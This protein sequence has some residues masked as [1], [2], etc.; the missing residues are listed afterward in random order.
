MKQQEVFNKIG[1][2][3]KELSDQYEYLKTAEDPLN[4]LELELFLA[5]SHFLTDH[6]V[7]LS[8]LNAQAIG[9]QKVKE[10]EKKSEPVQPRKSTTAEPPKNTEEPKYFEPLVQQAPA[11]KN[12]FESHEVSAEEPKEE[13]AEPENIILNEL[14]PV[15][16]ETPGTIRH[17][18]IIDEADL[19]DDDDLPELVEDKA[20]PVKPEPRPEPKPEPPIAAKEEKQPEKEA[21]EPKV[22]KEHVKQDIPTIN[23]RMSAQLGERNGISENI[24]LQPISDLKAAN[25]MN[26]KLL[27]VK[28]LFNGY[29][30]AYSEAIEILNRFSSFE[31]ADTFLKKNYVAKNNWDGKP[32]TTDKFY[33]ILRRRYA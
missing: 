26:D 13:K 10:S 20:A 22:V 16:P 31:E 1:G 19:D 12:G 21:P 18:L 4:E 5:N 29:S 24:N 2:I 9:A 25:N 3:I 7:I 23:E 14:F 30:L 32:E 15:D 11:A 6:M 28:D 8:K 33:S 17:E 27:Y